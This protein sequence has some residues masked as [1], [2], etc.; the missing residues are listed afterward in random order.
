[1]RRGWV[2]GLLALVVFVGF[3]GLFALKSAVES[4]ATVEFRGAAYDAPVNVGA[5][6]P[7]TAGLVPT[8]ERVRERQV[9]L[10][11]AAGPT[12][13]AVYLLRGDGSYTR[14]TLAR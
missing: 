8:Q 5:N 4:G 10:P 12:P 11:P 13:A 6:A 14:Y 9:F 1:M 2:L 3:G 7:E